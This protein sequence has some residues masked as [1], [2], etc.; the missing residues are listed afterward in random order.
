VTLSVVTGAS[1]FVGG[2]LVAELLAQGRAVRGVDLWRAPNLEGL[3]IDWREADVTDPT[4]LPHALEGADTVFHLAAIISISG[5]QGGRVRAVN[6]DG[7][8]NVARAALQAGVRR[9]VHCSSVHA[10]DLAAI[11][12][13]VTEASPRSTDERL[14]AYDRSKAA[15]EAAVRE[16]VAQGLD[17]VIVNPTG[18]IGP[19][20]HAP[21][22]MGHVF[23]AMFRGKIP[24]TVGGA[25]DWVDARDV[26]ASML[27]AEARGRTGESY[28][29][30]GHR[31]SMGEL[32]GVVEQVSGVRA[33]R[34]RVPMRLA[35][36]VTPLAE[37]VARRRRQ[38]LLFTREALH[39]LKSDPAVDGSKA[40]T[41]LG[42]EPR[43]LHE[44][45]ADIEAWFREQGDLKAG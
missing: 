41:E 36:A 30:P 23:V 32:A 11:K 3:D 4:T 45:V 43:P 28:L 1:G 22:R 42:H 18:V 29:L 44:S 5:D 2:I 9:H 24:A 13:P 27:V 25:F 20:D 21:S 26:V 7:A 37:S 33:P 34:L 6:V 16:V 15:G 12:G 8:G 31:A 19:G 17:G 40:R 39:A 14:P 35:D 10:F 38:P